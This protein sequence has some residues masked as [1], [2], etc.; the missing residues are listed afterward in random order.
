MLALVRIANRTRHWFPA[1]TQ[2]GL[3]PAAG[4]A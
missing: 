3:A 2:P 4:K 1:A